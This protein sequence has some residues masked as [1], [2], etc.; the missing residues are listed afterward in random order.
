M[1][2]RSW[3][4]LHTRY[5]TAFT[6]Y[7]M[8]RGF[9]YW[10]SNLLRFHFSFSVRINLFVTSWERGAMHLFIATD[11]ISARNNPQRLRCTRLNSSQRK[12]SLERCLTYIGGNQ[13][14]RIVEVRETRRKMENRGEAGEFDRLKAF[15]F[16][17]VRRQFFFFLDEKR[18]WHECSWPYRLYK[19][20]FPRR[21][22]IGAFTGEKVFTTP[23]CDPKNSQSVLGG[24]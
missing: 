1:T 8:I 14:Q 10:S 4:L 24:R 17:L 23:P 6:V 12:I 21:D 3:T 20:L 7:S 15:I 19:N 2:V 18:S 13:S 9:C 22:Y 5:W 16:F 11:S